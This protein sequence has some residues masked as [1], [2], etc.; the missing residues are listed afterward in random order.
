SWSA[1]IT[2][3]KCCIYIG[4]LHGICSVVDPFGASEM[5]CV[6]KLCVSPI[7]RKAPSAPVGDN[8]VSKCHD[9]K[10]KGKGKVL[11]N[12]SMRKSRPTSLTV[13]IIVHA[14]ELCRDG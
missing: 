11:P 13:L 7:K 3:H 5:K 14:F 6:C 1:T 4:Y 9:K 8:T 12:K 10:N 2:C